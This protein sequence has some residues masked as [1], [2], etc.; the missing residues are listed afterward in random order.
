LANVDDPGI[1]QELQE[2]V[3]QGQRQLLDF[4]SDTTG[5]SFNFGH[6]FTVPIGVPTTNGTLFRM[7]R[8]PPAAYILDLR[9]TPT[10]MDPGGGG[11]LAYDVVF[12]DDTG[13]VTVTAVLGSTKGRAASGSDR[14]ADGA[15][16]KFV[17]NKILALHVTTAGAAPAAGTYQLFLQFCI[18]LL[19]GTFGDVNP[20][21][22]GI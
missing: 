10:A 4:Q 12:V 2:F 5:I 9:G 14:I 21:D 7:R 3:R 8:M 17:G 18:G 6:V 1:G 11:T 20:T 22:Q 16:G 19:S 13:A 15:V